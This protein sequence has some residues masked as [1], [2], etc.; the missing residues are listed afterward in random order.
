MRCPFC[1]HLDSK[2]LDSRQTE[3]GASIRR[4]REC[5]ACHK[6][7]TTYERLDEVPF[8]VIKKD[9]RR[10]PFTRTK[11]LNGILRACE[12]RPISLQ[13]IDSLV[14]EIERDVRSG[15]DREISSEAIGEL[16]MDKLRMLD[17]VAYV[18]FASVYRQ[19]TDIERFM[20][21]LEQMRK[22]DN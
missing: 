2:V 17:E 22:A 18:R 15:L 3:E 11:I 13:T 21:E 9:G 5:M 19:F 4:R 8:M 12:K 7:F 14:D 10:E 1:L 20:E 16:V 6:R